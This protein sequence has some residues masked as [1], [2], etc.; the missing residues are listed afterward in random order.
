MRQLFFAITPVNE[1]SDLGVE[2][3]A[4]ARAAITV[5][6]EAAKTALARIWLLMVLVVE[7]EN[8]PAHV[9]RMQGDHEVET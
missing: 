8:E 5:E 6:Q 3:D 2:V 4:S 1:K 7:G 9:Q